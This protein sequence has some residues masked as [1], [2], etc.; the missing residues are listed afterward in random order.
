MHSA[1]LPARALID[2]AEAVPASVSGRRWAL[3]LIILVAAAVFSSLAVASR[4]DA[5]GSVLG[6]AAQSGELQKLTEQELADKVKQASRVKLVAGVAKAVFLMPLFVLLFAVAVKLAGWLINRSIRFADAF[7][8][9][10]VALLPISLFHIVFGAVVLSTPLVS[11][12]QALKLVPHHLGLVL[13]GLSPE[14]ARLASV[15]DFFNVWAALLLGLG[16]STATGMSRWKGLLFGLS[17]YVLFAGV[18]LV[19]LPAIAVGGGGR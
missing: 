15:V 8:V 17:L 12:A 14:L 7:T 3:P 18:F 1:L 5:A 4:W 10:A 2:P 19:G 16:Y 6:D 11:D 9:V 13:D